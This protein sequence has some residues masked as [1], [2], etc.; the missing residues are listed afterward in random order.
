MMEQKGPFRM[1]RE[2]YQQ[3]RKYS[4][5]DKEALAIIFAVKNTIIST[6][7]AMNLLYYLTISHRSTYLVNL[8]DISYGISQD[9]VMGNTPEWLP[10]SY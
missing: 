10:L 5:L 7:M 9:P 8:V 3:Q 4:Q 1:H 6:C 2:P